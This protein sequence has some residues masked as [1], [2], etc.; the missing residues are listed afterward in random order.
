MNWSKRLIL[1]IITVSL[2]GAGLLYPLVEEK[3]FTI[4]ATSTNSDEPKGG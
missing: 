3:E 2:L 4:V 1:S